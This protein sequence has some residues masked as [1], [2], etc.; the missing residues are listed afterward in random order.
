MAE[1][2]LVT[3]APD[4]PTAATESHKRKLDDLELSNEPVTESEPIA[5]PDSA[6][7]NEADGEENGGAADESDV[8]RPRLET[9]N[10]DDT[11]SQTDAAA[12]AAGN[13]Y[14]L[15]VSV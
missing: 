10:G 7:N 8:K 3:S 13:Y 2:D 9:S 12:A 4:S 1:E 11:V 5:D 6:A 15:L 14:A